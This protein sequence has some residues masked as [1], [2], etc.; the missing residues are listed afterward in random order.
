VVFIPEHGA[1]FRPVPGQIAGLR[2][3]PSAGITDVPVG[4]R[5]VGLRVSDMQRPL[6][7]EAS[8]SYLGLNLL[9]ANVLQATEVDRAPIDLARI[10]ARPQVTPFVAENDGL[11]VVRGGKGYHTRGPDGRWTP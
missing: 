9:L 3:V 8:T 1:A 7:V 6:R 5:L 2:Q 10:L 11:L 4:V